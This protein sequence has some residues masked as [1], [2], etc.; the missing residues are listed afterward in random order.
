VA[1][2]EFKDL[3]IDAH[4]AGLLADFWGRVLGLRVE[5]KADGDAVLRGTKPAGTIWVNAVP[6]PRTVKQRVHLDLTAPSLEPLITRGA[7]VVSPA[8]QSGHPWTVMADPEGGEFCVFVRDD[9]PTDP[10]A[11]RYELVVDTTDSASSK[12]QA[13]WWAEVF[14]ARSVDDGRG[15]WW[16]EDVPHLPFA[17]MDFV[18]V[19]EPKQVK[20]RIH[21]DVTSDDLAGLVDRGAT[22]LTHPT[23]TTPWHVCADPDGNEFC[24][25]APS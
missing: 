6:E 9:E 12:A 7:T 10:P 15:F 17:T 5:R 25:F 1:L 4:D 20:N 23:R 11:R 14:G 3:C 24:V 16:L 2:A 22:V 19:P 18:P 13:D 21:W 8:E